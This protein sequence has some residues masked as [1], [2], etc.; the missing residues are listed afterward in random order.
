M[1]SQFSLGLELSKITPP[2]FEQGRQVLIETIKGIQI[3]GSNYVTETQ[4]AAVLGR[5]LI[6]PEFAVKFRRLVGSPGTYQFTGL[7]RL[8]LE[9]GPG[10]TLKHAFERGNDAYFSMVVQISLF[11]F[12]YQESSLADMISN[13]LDEITYKEASDVPR[14]EN[15]RGTIRSII[16]QGC[17]F[18]WEIWFVSIDARLQK[19]L[20]IPGFGPGRYH[21]GGPPYSIFTGLIGALPLVYRFP[22]SYIL[23]IRTYPG[24]TFEVLWAHVLLGLTVEVK[25]EERRCVF[26]SRSTSVFVDC[27]PHNGIGRPDLVLMRT[28]DTTHAIEWSRTEDYVWDFQP[29][30]VTR[31]TIK[32]FGEKCLEAGYSSIAPQKSSD[33]PYA[34]EHAAKLAFQAAIT[35][36]K[37]NIPCYCLTRQRIL[38]TI[39]CLFPST[40]FPADLG[41]SWSDE[42]LATWESQKDVSSNAALGGYFWA[43]QALCNIILALST[44]TDLEGCQEATLNLDRRTCLEAVQNVE[45]TS[46]ADA[47]TVLEILIDG[48]LRSA[49]GLSTP[50]PVAIVS[51]WGWSLCVGS[52]LGGDPS[53]LTPTIG[54][55]KGVPSRSGERKSYVLDHRNPFHCH[56]NHTLSPNPTDGVSLSSYYLLSCGNVNAPN[57]IALCSELRTYDTGHMIGVSGDA[58][59]VLKTGTL[60]DSRGLLVS[61]KIGLRHMQDLY[62]NIIHLSTCDCSKKPRIGNIFTPQRNCWVFNGIIGTG[63]RN[64]IRNYDGKVLEGWEDPWELAVNPSKGPKGLAAKLARAEY[65]PEQLQEQRDQLNKIIPYRDPECRIH[66]GLTAGDSLAR[67]FLLA[68]SQSTR[69]KPSDRAKQR[70]FNGFYLRHSDCCV[71][72]GMKTIRDQIHGDNVAYAHALM[73]L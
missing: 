62:W 24:P 58:F 51:A 41:V 12:V 3:S 34:A 42:Q 17:S 1:N 8:V 19:D 40:P 60:R 45:L 54:L 4:L 56:N 46:M 39:R 5:V 65:T 26:G 18:N 68:Q 7:L 37:T 29:T 35:R 63:D 9:Q 44:I 6:Q 16:E 67:W 55:I 22:E 14:P 72:C 11:S 38:S 71:E 31:H 50:R 36:Q 61:L 20:Q 52:V 48:N 25:Y 23:D 13:T 10:P 47:F 30:F 27:S 57:P 70:Y 43:F 66:L 59:T 21:R 32:G 33:I 69:L 53:D 2:V 64:D 15:L 28:T 73:I 49:S